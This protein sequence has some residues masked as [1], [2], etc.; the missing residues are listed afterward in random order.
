MS[1]ICS[2]LGALL[3]VITLGTVLPSLGHHQ[4]T[5]RRNISTR[6]CCLDKAG[7]AFLGFNQPYT[8]TS[9]VFREYSPDAL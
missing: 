1:R 5:T 8:I 4:P 3:I 6:Q 7:T 9:Q 2:S